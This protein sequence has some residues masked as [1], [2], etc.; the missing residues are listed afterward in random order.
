M[1]TTDPEPVA[2][3][4]ILGER[5]AKAPAPASELLK[6]KPVGPSGIVTEDGRMRTTT[7][8]KD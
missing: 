3:K 5:V 1:R 6:P 7:H 4:P 2:G 8:P